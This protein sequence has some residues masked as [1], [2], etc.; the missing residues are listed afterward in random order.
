MGRKRQK[1]L[2]TGMFDTEF[3]FVIENNPALAPWADLLRD[4]WAAQLPGKTGK[5]GRGQAIALTRF[6][7]GYLH[8]QG[9]AELSVAAFF[10][11]SRVLP[12]LE[13]VMEVN[14]GATFVQNHVVAVD[15]L[16]WVLRERLSVEDADGHRVVPEHL[17]LPFQ[18]LRKKVHGKES[19]LDFMHVLRLDPKLEDWRALA[20]TWLKEQTIGVATKRA[21]LDAFLAEY[22]HGHDLDRNFGQFLLRS[23]PKPAFMDVRLAAKSK[24]SAGVGRDDI[25]RN[26]YVAD[27][28]DW[29]L[30]TRLGDEGV[31]DSTRFHNPVP[32]LTFTGLATATESNKAVLS[33]KYIKECRSLLAEGATF[34]D[35][36]WAQA[37]ISEGS[38]GGDWCKCL[39]RLRST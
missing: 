2:H 7:I 35:W 3:R 14:E 17:A 20:A 33:I 25:K 16:D 28:L 12:S 5:T 29:V 15:F 30:D 8:G 34:S 9:L 4:Y 19:D 13:A 22:L 36:T 18:R 31:W 32:R 11:K 23:T 6:A 27:F 39:C 21:A 26:N 1:K 38:N 24:G 37:A 10:E